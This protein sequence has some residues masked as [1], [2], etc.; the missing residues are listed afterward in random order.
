M[1]E[2]LTVQQWQIEAIKEGIAAAE[3]GDLI[4]HEEVR[5]WVESWG[6]AHELPRPRPRSK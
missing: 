3:R 4:P 1:E 2:F 5:A 6:S